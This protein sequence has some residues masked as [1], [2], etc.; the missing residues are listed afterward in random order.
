MKQPFLDS[1]TTISR[2]SEMFETISFV[3]RWELYCETWIAW[4][5][6][7]KPSWAYFSVLATDSVTLIRSVKFKTGSCQ[8]VNTSFVIMLFWFIGAS[9][10]F[11]NMPC[12]KVNFQKFSRTILWWR[13]I[14][15]LTLVTCANLMA[16]KC[17]LENYWNKK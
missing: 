15:R 10:Q 8:L 6:L 3:N 5:G 9:D 16:I 12:V 7:S 2:V 1:R 17:S 4:I 11:S 13:Y 14:Q